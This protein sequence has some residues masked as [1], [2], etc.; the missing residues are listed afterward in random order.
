MYVHVTSLDI[1]SLRSISCIQSKSH[2]PNLDLYFYP[3]DLT[4]ELTHLTINAIQS[5]ATTTEDQDVGHFTRRNLK[6]LSTWDEWEK[7]EIKQANNMHDIWMSGKII[8]SPKNEIVF[9][10]H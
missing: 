1:T 8:E 9:R 3:E 2:F 4:T 6:R 5:K 10:P 7:S